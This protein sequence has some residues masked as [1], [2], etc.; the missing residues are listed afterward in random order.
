M[1]IAAIKAV[2]EESAFAAGGDDG[3]ISSRTSDM[4]GTVDGQDEISVITMNVEDI[5]SLGSSV[6]SLVLDE[7]K[8]H[9]QGEFNDP[10][11]WEEDQAPMKFPS[12]AKSKVEGP[13]VTQEEE[14]VPDVA[15][16]AA[17]IMGTVVEVASQ[18][19]PRT[20]R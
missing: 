3:W 19:M 16:P 6:P 10:Q 13:A 2:Q 4:N 17:S 7:D 18:G 9:V 11:F 14:V 20:A 15:V 12:V 1:D 8:L 5:S